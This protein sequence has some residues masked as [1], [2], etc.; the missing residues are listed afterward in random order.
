M[1][2]DRPVETMGRDE[3]IVALA[4][5]CKARA[6]RDDALAFVAA[7][8]NII[9]SSIEGATHAEL[10]GDLCNLYRT[11]QGDTLDHARRDIAKR[12]AIC[13]ERDAAR[14]EAVRLRAALADARGQ[15]AWASRMISY[16]GRPDDYARSAHLTTDALVLRIDAVLAAKDGG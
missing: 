3:L 6:E 2:A 10:V 12:H 1:P 8:D 15:V 13:A 16:T 11:R 4:E 14:A 5:A 9:G 7:I